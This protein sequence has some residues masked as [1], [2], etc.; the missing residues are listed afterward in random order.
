MW[1]VFS[2]ESEFFRF[3][4][5][6]WFIEMSFSVGAMANGLRME[7]N[8]GKAHDVGV[9]R[10]KQAEKPIPEIL[11]EFQSG[12]CISTQMYIYKD[13]KRMRHENKER[14]I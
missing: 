3:E 11:S 5:E 10:G 6:I 14:Y 12:F 8:Y 9:G 4:L 2:I 13:K 1:N 7:Y